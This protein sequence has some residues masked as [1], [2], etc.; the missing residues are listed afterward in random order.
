[1]VLLGHLREW[2]GFPLPLWTNEESMTRG[3]EV[4]RAEVTRLDSLL[5]DPL[6]TRQ[7]SQPIR[8]AR[9]GGHPET[10]RKAWIPAFA[11]MTT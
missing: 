8:H 3:E 5:R 11:G 7:P 2:L 4:V 9:A 6:L 10:P 1:M